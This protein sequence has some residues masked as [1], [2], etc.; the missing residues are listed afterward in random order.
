M[1]NKSS[2]K[3]THNTQNFVNYIRSKDAYD[4]NMEITNLKASSQKISTPFKTDL[5]ETNEDK[6]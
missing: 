6:Q 3:S 1:K 4:G 5:T 2:N